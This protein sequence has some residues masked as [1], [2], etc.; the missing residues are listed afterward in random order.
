MTQ[1]KNGYF[2]RVTRIPLPRTDRVFCVVMHGLLSPIVCW[3]LEMRNSFVN[4]SNRP[5]KHFV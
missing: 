5:V 1:R 3:A 2:A 4:F